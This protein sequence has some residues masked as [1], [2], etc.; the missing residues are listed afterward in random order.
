MGKQS[1]PP[2]QLAEE[3]AA[4]LG[5]DQQSANRFVV[6]THTMALAHQL[7]G[8]LD[9]G[10]EPGEELRSRLAG[11]DS[12]ALPRRLLRRDR[13]SLHWA[14]KIPALLDAVR[15]GDDEA[16]RRHVETLIRNEL[17]GDVDSSD[18]GDSGTRLE[19]YYALLML[20]GDRMGRIL[21]G[22]ANA[23]PYRKSFHPQVRDGF[24][25]RSEGNAAVRQYGEQ[26]RAISPNR[27]LAVSG[28]LND[29]AL[30]IVPE[31]VERE[32][33]GRIIYAGGDDVLAIL[34]AADLLPAM[35][36]LRN[37]YSGDA[38]ENQGT[39]WQSARRGGRL[40]CNDGF[41][42]L[43]NRLMRMMAGATASCGAV[44][45]H[46]QTPLAAVLRELR[47]A[48]QRAKNEGDRDA[49]SITV[50]KRSGG[51]L[52]LTAKWGEPI[53]LLAKLRGFLA[54]FAVSRRAV[55]HSLLWLRDLPEDTKPDMLGSLLSYQLTRQTGSKTVLD[56]HD[57][58]GL[59]K[60]L[61]ELATR[62]E[63]PRPWLTSFF[64]MAEF[65]AREARMPNP[66]ATAN[67]PATE[68]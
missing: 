62:Q 8:W 1:A 4:A 46:Y 33:L 16:E 13:P 21:S 35:Q 3:V 60:C 24:D 15:E 10:R 23:I 54:E 55:Y 50:L 61:V 51:D 27:H 49:F 52:R 36:R 37:A 68:E 28:A 42:L 9:T 48:E 58:P 67:P 32:H 11:V 39:D 20:D 25:R 5:P 34:P 12:V 45:A 38:H 19:T 2:Q 63:Q 53:D 56:D 14:K 22:D 59:A 30:H 40:V 31:V 57:V 65:L 44:I 7:D 64:S 66:S 17:R 43:N 26:G 47:A 18:H 41:A 6:S 29:F